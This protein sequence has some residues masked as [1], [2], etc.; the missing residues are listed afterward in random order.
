MSLAKGQ[1]LLQSK[2]LPQLVANAVQIK[3]L[4]VVVLAIKVPT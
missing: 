3:H 1:L 4:H 2:K